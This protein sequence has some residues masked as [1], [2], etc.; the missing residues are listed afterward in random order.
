MGGEAA[1]SARWLIEAADAGGGSVWLEQALQRRA[2]REPLQYIIGRWPFYSLE[3][4]L[5][6]RPPVLIP[7]P[8]TEELVELIISGY[9]AAPGPRRILDVGSGTGAICI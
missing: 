4:E 3:S 1:A 7:R 2:R 6:V 9:E 8:E 5:L